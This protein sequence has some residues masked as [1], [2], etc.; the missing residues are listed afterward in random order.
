MNPGL[1]EQDVTRQILGCFFKVYNSLGYGF[2][3]KVYEKALAIEL[4]NKGLTV[5]CQQG[6]KVYYEGDLIGEYC[7]DI[8]V[9][10]TVIIE[11]KVADAIH[12][13]HESQLINY[14]KATE[15][16]IGLLLNF[17]PKPTFVRKFFSNENKKIGAKDADDT[18]Q[19]DL[20]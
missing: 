3:E 10:G 2:L 12:P 14:L 19:A 8:V 16:E 13:A 11:L 20:R 18:D 4:R 6:V 7:A 5:V 15:I 9:N 1:K 17:G